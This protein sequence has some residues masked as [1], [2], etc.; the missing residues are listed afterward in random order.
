MQV[1]RLRTLENPG[2]GVQTPTA[3]LR[4]N[5]A[6]H[7]LSQRTRYRRGPARSWLVP[8]KLATGHGYPGSQCRCISRIERGVKNEGWQPRPACICTSPTRPFSL[9]FGYVLVCHR[10]PLPQRASLH[11]ACQR[12]TV[13]REEG[14]RGR[15]R[16]HEN[17]RLAARSRAPLTQRLDPLLLSPG[18]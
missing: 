17:G 2:G 14:T 1:G 4:Y 3:V 18:R 9:L 15:E 7:H 13:G 16:S 10:S 5:R 12:E 8:G 6:G 11:Q